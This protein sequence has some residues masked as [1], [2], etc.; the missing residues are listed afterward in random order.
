VDSVSV[1][2]AVFMLVVLKIPVVY[3]GG[4]V[5]WAVRA[6]PLPEGGDETN[7]P[8]S[9]GPCGWDEWRRRRSRYPARRPLRPFGPV[10]PPAPAR[11]GAQI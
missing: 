8:A 10:R 1:W 7:V 3:L 2:E 11:A 9:L 6:E 5:W 4:V